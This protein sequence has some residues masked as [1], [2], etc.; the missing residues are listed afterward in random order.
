VSKQN[1]T[2]AA[3]QEQRVNELEHNRKKRKQTSDTNR[4]TKK[5]RLIDVTDICIKFRQEGWENVTNNEFELV[6]GI[7]LKSEP[8]YTK[9][10]RTRHGDKNGLV[11]RVFFKYLPKTMWNSLLVTMN[12]H[13]QE[14]LA[15]GSITNTSKYREVSRK[16]LWCW[17][18]M[19]IYSGVKEMKDPN[20]I[21]KV[22]L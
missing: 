10:V 3:D 7:K 14:L 4:R 2:T 5:K 12:N 19:C 15:N 16:E 9:F 6:A 17:L 20:E 21:V 22:S 8:D 13:R 18:A 11:E 1:R